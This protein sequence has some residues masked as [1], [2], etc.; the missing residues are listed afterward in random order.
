MPSSSETGHAKN[1][2]NFENLVAFVT[3]YGTKYNPY[4]E[5]LKLPDLQN[6]LAAARSALEDCKTKKTTSI[7]PPMPAGMRLTASK[8]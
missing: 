6:Q 2:A 7:M 5:S 3:G 8:L 4:R 1:V